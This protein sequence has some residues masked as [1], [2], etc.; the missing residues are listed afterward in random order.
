MLNLLYM[1]MSLNTTWEKL[2]NKLIEQ[3]IR[4][5]K[6]KKTIKARLISCTFIDADTHQHIIYCPAINVTSYGS[7]IERAVEMF[8]FSL[9]EFCKHLIATTQDKAV[10]ELKELGWKQ[11]KL[12]RKE[13]SNAFVGIDGQLKNFNIKDGSL[14]LQAITAD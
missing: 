9:E 14:E 1:S 2:P 12:K 5:D 7:T 11:Q 4:I 3:S 8:K 10:S 13:F 6:S